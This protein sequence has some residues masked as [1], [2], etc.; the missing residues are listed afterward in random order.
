M[1]ATFTN[2]ADGSPVELLVEDFFGRDATIKFD[3]S[4]VAKVHRK[5]FNTRQILAGD[6]TVSFCVK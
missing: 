3:G 4:C 5:F 2:S 6:R 1:V